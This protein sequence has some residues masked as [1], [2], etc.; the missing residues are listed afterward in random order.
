MVLRTAK[1][2][3][4]F[5]VRWFFLISLII[6][7][8]FLIY[9]WHGYIWK[10]DWNDEKKQQYISEQAKFT[11]D[12]SGYQKMLTLMDGRREKLK[13]FSPFSGRDAFF[14]EGF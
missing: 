6:V 5:F 1:K 3:S 10:A 8:L 14:P 4:S 12:K 9:V 13:N 11:F 2:I 7:A